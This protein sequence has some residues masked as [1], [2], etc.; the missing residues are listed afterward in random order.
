[1]SQRWRLVC[2]RRGKIWC[3]SRE[4]RS[5]SQ[6]VRKECITA[7]RQQRFWWKGHVAR[8][9]KTPSLT[10]T[11][12]GWTTEKSSSQT[13]L[14]QTRN[15]KTQRLDSRLALLSCRR[16][17]SSSLSAVLKETIRRIKQGRL[18]NLSLAW[19]EMAIEATK[20]GP[21]TGKDSHHSS[22]APV[23]SVFSWNVRLT[24]FI[25]RQG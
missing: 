4:R 15:P 17:D 22:P 20:L 6:S 8:D 25:C 10:L 23:P 3:G 24:H 16:K 14:L 1:M 7:P 12:S 13:S 19:H 18:T 21:P 11:K 5:W 9:S 2:K